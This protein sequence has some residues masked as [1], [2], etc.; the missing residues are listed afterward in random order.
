MF[1]KRLDTKTLRIQ[2]HFASTY[3]TRYVLH[4][5]VR[6]N[7]SK[8][9]SLALGVAICSASFFLCTTL[10]VKIKGVTNTVALGKSVKENV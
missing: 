3:S 10:K 9:I 4:I 5:S 7:T 1:R 2:E 6:L 8:V